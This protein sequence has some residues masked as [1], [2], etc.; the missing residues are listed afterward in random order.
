MSPSAPNLDPQWLDRMYNNRALVPEHAR[1]FA[2]WD[3][4][5]RR[6]RERLP[7]QLDLAYGEGAGETLDLFPSPRPG[8]PVLVFIHGG[9]W[10]ALDKAGHSFVAP[11]FTAAGSCVVVPNYAL[12]PAVSIPQ[13]TLQMVKALAWV[14]RQ[15][16]L[17]GG[18]PARI[19]VVGHSAGGQL[20]AMLLNC[21]WRAFGGDLPPDLVKNALSISGLYDLEPIR[22]T[23]FLKESLKLTPAQV[24]QASPALLPRPRQGTLY[25]VVGASESDEYLRQNLLIQQVWGDKTVPVCESQLGLNHFSVLEALVDPAHRLHRLALDLLGL[26]RPAPR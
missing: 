11:A 4:D 20:A 21:D 1:H 26:P 10:R 9:Y 7:C 3:E 8:A 5:S 12:A 15:I 24:L 6:A 2:R 16:A 22:Q 23:P 14:W 17:H 18:D 19:T 25:S 13:I